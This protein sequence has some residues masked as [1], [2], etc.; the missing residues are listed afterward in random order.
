M[1]YTKRLDISSNNASYNSLALPKTK[2]SM[3]SAVPI[4]NRLRFEELINNRSRR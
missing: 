4:S 1:I 2:H 3:K